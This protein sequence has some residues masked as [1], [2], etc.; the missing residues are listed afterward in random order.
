MINTCNAATSCDEELTM[1]N[2]LSQTDRYV[3]DLLEA[4]HSLSENIFGELIDTNIDPVH[5]SYPNGAVGK[6][7][8]EN[9]RLIVANAILNQMIRKV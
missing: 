7:I 6:I 5:D 1:S 4:I 2:A 9:D 8:Y 3:T